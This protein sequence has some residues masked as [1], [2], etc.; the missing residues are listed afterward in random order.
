MFLFVCF[1]T[2]CGK[3]GVNSENTAIPGERNESSDL[4]DMQMPDR[5]Q[6]AIVLTPPQNEEPLSVTSAF[7]AVLLNEETVF[8]TDQLLRSG[9]GR[10]FEGLLS[11]MPYGYDYARRI[12]RFAVVDL[13]GD[14]I[15]EVVLELAEYAGF[16]VLRYRDGQ[17]HG[18]VFGYRSMNLLKENGAFHSAGSAFEGYVGKLCFIGDTAVTDDKLSFLLS[19]NRESYYIDSILVDSSEYE[20][21]FALFSE[22]PEAEWYNYTEETVREI[23]GEG[24]LFRE[25]SAEAAENAKERQAYLDSLSYLFDLTCDTSKT[26]EEINAD[27]KSYYDGCYE[28]MNRIYQLCQERLSGEALEA[29]NAEQQRWEE[30]NAETL[31]EEL[32]HYHANSIEELEDRTLY[33]TYGDIAL[34]R[35]IRMINLYYGFDFYDW[36]KNDAWWTAYLDIICNMQEYL[37]DTIDYRSDPELYDPMDERIYLGLHDFDGDLIPELLIGDDITMAVFTFSDGKAEKLENLYHP[38]AGAW[39][40][41]GVYFR[42]NS[43]SLEC[44]GAGGADYVNFGYLD[45]EYVIGLYSQLSQPSVVK[46]NGEE[47]TL[48]EMDRIYP[49]DGHAR[50][51][52]DRREKLRLV[53]EDGVWI[54]VFPSEE[55]VAL[56]QRFDCDL[57][58]W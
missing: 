34:R 37:V 22:T 16:I 15:P 1:F 20:R 38:D 56:D 27:A 49:T 28:E 3:E 35:T 6:D 14:A 39:C 42:D 40:I 25:P 53:N 43:I 10:E 19:I 30:S 48:E 55:Q 8:C 12:D 7:R 44:D 9:V 45:G 26:L 51:S 50:A 54:L 24:V 52:E 13:D 46:I 58:M 29:L 57:I 18:N 33:D 31:E 17:I 47:S 2:G 5:S 4:Q 23:F 11:E 36:I 41:N 32:Q 21:A